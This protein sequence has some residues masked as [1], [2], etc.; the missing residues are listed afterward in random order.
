MR[1][2]LFF[3]SCPD[4]FRA[5]TSFLAARE[6]D[7]DGRDKPGHDVERWRADLPLSGGGQ[8]SIERR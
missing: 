8:K 2:F 7:V 1:S 6:Q 3:S 5:S 4:L